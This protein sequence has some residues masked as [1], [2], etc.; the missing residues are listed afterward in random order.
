MSYPCTYHTPTR[1]LI[2]VLQ[3]WQVLLAP[4][5]AVSVSEVTLADALAVI[6]AMQ[7]TFGHSASLETIIQHLVGQ[8]LREQ[9]EQRAASK[10]LVGAA[11]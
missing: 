4:A 8:D 3:Q 6:E 5:C 11:A 7:Q 9:V 1:R 10:H 2:G